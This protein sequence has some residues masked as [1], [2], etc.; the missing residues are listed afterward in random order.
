MPAESR[1]NGP[2]A[3]L[4]TAELAMAD[5]WSA[6]V[7]AAVRQPDAVPLC[8]NCLCPQGPHPHFCPNCAFPTGDRVAAMHYLNVFVV[9][10]LVRQGVSGPPERRWGVKA[11]LV[12]LGAL[13]YSVFAPIYWYWLWRR[14]RGRPICN[15]ERPQLPFEEASTE[16]PPAG[17]TVYKTGDPALWGRVSKTELKCSGNRINPEKRN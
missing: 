13:Q 17:C 1:Y 4:F 15:G 3:R 6:E 8:S 14:A 9:G 12:V 2:L 16:R 11:F 5:P 10:E 7:E